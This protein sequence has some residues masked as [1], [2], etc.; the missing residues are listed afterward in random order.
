MAGSGVN[1]LLNW[2]DGDASLGGSVVRPPKRVWLEERRP[3]Q[4]S[5]EFVVYQLFDRLFRRVLARVGG[6]LEAEVDRMEPTRFEPERVRSLWNVAPATGMR[7]RAVYVFRN[8]FGDESPRLAAHRLGDV[9]FD[10]D[11]TLDLS[12]AGVPIGSLGVGSVAGKLL[13]SVDPTVRL[14]PV[15]PWSTDAGSLREFIFEYFSAIAQI[16]DADADIAVRTFEDLYR[17][18]LTEEAPEGWKFELFPDVIEG[19]KGD[20][21]P[22]EI[23]ITAPTPGRTLLAVQAEKIANGA[24]NDQADS[25]WSEIVAVEVTRQLDILLFTDIEPRTGILDRLER[26][27]TVAQG[28]LLRLRR[29]QRQP[30]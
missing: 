3:A 24:E 21:V 22:F 9:D 1:V 19:S 8:D 26:A 14:R 6:K 5:D 30:V 27:L 16:A 25:M 15:V 11:P 12:A 2:T 17:P 10:F 4:N 29:G 20:I 28:W 23:R 13:F 7:M 18:F